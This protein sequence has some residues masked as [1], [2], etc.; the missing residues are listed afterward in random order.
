MIR[1]TNI[2]RLLFPVREQSVYLEGQS[3]PVR[4]FKAIAGGFGQNEKI[5]SIVSSDYKLFTNEEALD[6]GK[7]IHLK[8]FPDASPESFELFH[9]RAPKTGSNCQIDFIDKKYKFSISGKEEYFAFV[10]I[11]NSYNRTRALQFDIGFCRAICTNG[12]IYEKDSVQYKYSHTR[13]SM[14]QLDL[15]SINVAHLKKLE[16]KFIN[17]A[18]QSQS[19][20]LDKK[21]YVALAAKVLGKQFVITDSN[22]KQSEKEKEKLKNFA[23]AINNYTNI[24]T[25]EM[26]ETAY[27]FYN[28]VTDFASNSDEIKESAV[29]GLQTKCGLWINSLGKLVQSPEFS[30]EKELEDYQYLLKGISKN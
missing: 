20:N 25:P 2:D 14:G 11:H 18:N 16:Q 6:M 26:G 17:I 29:N 10:R 30:W 3:T 24:Y 7:I 28:V 9:I 27:A 22:S 4:G 23:L 21:Y 12:V 15:N 19:I 1:N 13:Q 8:L 5:F